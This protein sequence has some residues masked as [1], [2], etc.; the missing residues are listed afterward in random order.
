MSPDVDPRSR[1]A[2]VFPELGARDVRA[3]GTG[4]TVDTYEVDDG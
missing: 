2:T 3:I 4:W 1:V